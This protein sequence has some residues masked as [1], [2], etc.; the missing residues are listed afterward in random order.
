M[1]QFAQ[2]WWV[3]LFILVPIV[4]Y[5]LWY[6]KKLIIDKNVLIKTAI[7]GIA[8]AFVEAA[9]VIYLRAAV[10]L[11]PNYGG[12]LSDITSLSSNLYQQAQILNNLPRSLF[13]IEFIRE[14]ATMIMLI[15]ISIL[16]VRNKKERWAIFIWMFAFWDIFYYLW[17]WITVKWPISLLSSDV[18][19]LIP[20]A[21]L[22]QVWFPILVSLLCIITVILCNKNHRTLKSMHTR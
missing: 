8:F 10:G 2:P 20:T 4:T 16:A 7:F 9:V 14:L 22:S 11:L 15:S 21:W 6:K 12:T 3:N 13:F 18:L 5:F 17:L 19:F 1:I